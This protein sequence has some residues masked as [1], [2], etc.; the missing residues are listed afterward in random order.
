MLQIGGLD[1][2]DKTA[3]IERAT[4]MIVIEK[5]IHADSFISYKQ[6]KQKRSTACNSKEVLA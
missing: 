5:Y 4:E 6:N 1:A 3:P 2:R